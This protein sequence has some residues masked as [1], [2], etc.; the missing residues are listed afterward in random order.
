MVRGRD[1]VTLIRFFNIRKVNRKCR[2]TSRTIGFFFSLI[3]EFSKL[4]IPV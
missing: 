2:T 3:R 1:I 4:S